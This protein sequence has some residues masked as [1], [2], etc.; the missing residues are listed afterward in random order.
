M[1]PFSG[2]GASIPATSLT[3]LENSEVKEAVDLSFHR[4]AGSMAVVCREDLIGEISILGQREQSRG[5]NISTR[6]LNI[7]FLEEH[8]SGVIT[9]DK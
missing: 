4:L 6:I 3:G 7:I 5:S 1:N 8:N 9:T 2:G